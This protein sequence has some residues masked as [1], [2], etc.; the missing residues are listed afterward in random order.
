MKREYGMPY[1]GSKRK[2]SKHLISYMLRKNPNAKY[3]YDLFGGGGAMSFEALHY[4]QLKE[5]HYNE[6]NAGVVAL[7]KDVLENG[8]TDKYYKWIDRETFNK[9]KGDNSWLGGLRK[10]VWSFGNNQSCYLFGSE[11]EED[12]R[13]LHEIVVNA[14]EKSLK[15]FNEKHNMNIK[16]LKTDT[17]IKKRRLRVKK[18]IKIKLKNR[19]GELERLERLEQLER[20]ERLLNKLTIHNK[21]YNEVKITTPLEETIIYL[22][23]PYENTAKY[24]KDISHK[25]LLKWIKQQKCKVYV[26]SYEFDGLKKV[27][28]KTHRSTLNATA[29][30]EVE[31]KLFLWGGAK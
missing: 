7:L 29:N 9:H 16:L 15:I 19:D 1:M 3:F 4:K 22:D 5:V 21:S 25:E 12:K 20:L 17:T 28:S 13:L 27:Y 30:N 6:Y 8:V 31:E 14:C 10:V 18:I 2:L 11:I 23:P 26:S 24:E